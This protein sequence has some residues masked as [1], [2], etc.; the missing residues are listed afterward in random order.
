MFGK[1]MNKNDNRFLCGNV[2]AVGLPQKG[3]LLNP[4]G[5]APLFAGRSETLD[6]KKF[7]CRFFTPAG[8]RLDGNIV[9]TERMREK[10]WKS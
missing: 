10:S 1:Y 4:G 8:K 7:S 5:G 2:I 9:S 6:S 3:D